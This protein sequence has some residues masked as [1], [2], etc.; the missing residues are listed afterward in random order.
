MYGGIYQIYTPGEWVTWGIVQL[1]GLRQPGQWQVQALAR[2]GNRFLWL[3]GQNYMDSCH[4]FA[5]EWLITI[6]NS[7][8]S[9]PLGKPTAKILSLQKGLTMSLDLRVK[10]M[11]VYMPH[12]WKFF[13]NMQWIKSS[14]Q[15]SLQRRVSWSHSLARGRGSNLLVEEGCAAPASTESLKRTYKN[16]PWNQ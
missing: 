3:E 1:P 7:I 2:S 11:E 9:V 16:Y 12:L 6:Y 13:V 10:P 5:K 4:N 14:S 15:P 8:N